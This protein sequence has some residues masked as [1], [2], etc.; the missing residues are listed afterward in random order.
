MSKFPITIFLPAAGL[1][2]RMR[3]ITNHM[4]KP[5]LPILGKPLIGIILEKLTAVCDGKIGIN[6]HYKADMIREW[7][8][9]SH[10]AHRV[11]FF[12]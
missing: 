12:P 6:L 2:E 10:Y 11:P 7:V 4:P 9:S 3:P 5:L 8:G 1:G